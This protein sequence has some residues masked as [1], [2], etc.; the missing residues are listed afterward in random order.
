MMISHFPLYAKAPRHYHGLE[1]TFF[2]QR[3]T[4]ALPAAFRHDF[5]TI[6]QKKNE[7][8]NT[9]KPLSSLESKR[10]IGRKLERMRFLK[11]LR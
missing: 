6:R 7:N 11:C 8:N 1:T 10:N 4:K 3:K 2:R 9:D 5:P